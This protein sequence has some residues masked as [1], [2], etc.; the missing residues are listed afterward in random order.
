MV[1]VGV[2]GQAAALH[3]PSYDSTQSFQQQFQNYYSFFFCWGG[4]RLKSERTCGA[5]T[6][7]GQ[8][9]P[10]QHDNNVGALDRIQPDQNS[11]H[12][13]TRAQNTKNIAEILFSSVLVRLINTHTCAHPHTHTPTR[14]ASFI[15]IALADLWA[16]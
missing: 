1:A 15:I 3:Y 13:N 4:V 11:Q 2:E 14:T 9:A 7:L 8:S 10:L 16:I 12:T 6:H 5:H